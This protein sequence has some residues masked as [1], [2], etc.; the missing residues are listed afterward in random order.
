MRSSIWTVADND[1]GITGCEEKDVKTENA[2]TSTP[3]HAVVI[4]PRGEKVTIEMTAKQADVL[5]W[6][7]RGEID[8]DQFQP[9]TMNTL[10]QIAKRVDA[11]C[12][13]RPKIDG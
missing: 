10:K 5:W 1:K 8:R 12:G 4:R 6:L 11:A 9:R 3:V 2:K 7:L 13:F